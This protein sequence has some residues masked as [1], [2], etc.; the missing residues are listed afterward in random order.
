MD[1]VAL[2][3][4]HMEQEH[5]ANPYDQSKPY[6]NV[7]NEDIEKQC[8][9]ESDMMHQF[10]L[11]SSHTEVPYD[12]EQFWV[13]TQSYQQITPFDEYDDMHHHTNVYISPIQS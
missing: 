3:S 6:I 7:N 11:S 9:E 2:G 8:S 12:L 13:Y 5:A 4:L 1:L 10:Q